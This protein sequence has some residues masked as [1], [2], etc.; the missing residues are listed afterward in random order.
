MHIHLDPLGGVAG[1]MFAAAMLD[2]WPEHRAP[3]FDALAV[4]GA[5]SNV[6][7]ELLDHNDGTLTGRRFHVTEPHGHHH[8]PYA[9]VR[10]RIAGSRLSAAIR[11]RALAIFALLG[12]AEAEVHGIPVEEVSFHE[13]GAWDSIVDVVSA[14]F[15]IDV[16]GAGSWSAGPLPMG[17][18]RVATAH[19]DLPVPAPAT[20]HLLRGFLLFD[21]GRPGERI[22]PTG[23]AI[24][25]HLAPS[26]RGPT[27]PR[28]LL[29]TG[30]GFGTRRLQGISNALRV[31][32]FEAGATAD[33]E[34][35]AVLAFEVDDQTAEDLAV[36]MERLRATDGVLD[37]WQAPVTGKKGRL[38][39]AV[40]L[41]VRPDQL[42]DV[43]DRCF[44]ET[45]T[46]GLRWNTAERAVLPRRGVSVAEGRAKVVDRHGRKS[47]KAEIDDI[48]KAG[49]HI[50]RETRRRT[51]EDAA[52]KRDDED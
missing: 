25:R 11:D 21:D 27:P 52:L 23:A 44:A 22:T 7:V 47:A 13:V 8:T 41:L 35:V 43:I 3:L 6:T 45:T 37:A 48:A 49:D 14:A 28:R 31:M 4:L 40:R 36:A 5:P 30:F 24:L 19:G 39:T 12:E 9:E 15:L 17:S 38:A 10:S 2:A 32:A 20:A 51:V 33:T 18:G 42:N 46:I 26:Q 34:T 29:R 16:V 50:D 1:D